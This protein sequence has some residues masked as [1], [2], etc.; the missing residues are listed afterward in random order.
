MLGRQTRTA[1]AQNADRPTSTR[2]SATHPEGWK[3]NGR[4]MQVESDSNERNRPNLGRKRNLATATTTTTTTTTT[5]RPT[6]EC[7]SAPRNDLVTRVLAVPA[8]PEARGNARPA[9]VARLHARRPRGAPSHIQV[10]FA[11]RARAI[12]RAMPPPLVSMLE[13]HPCSRQPPYVGLWG[14]APMDMI[15]HAVYV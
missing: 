4:N 10:V 9:L 3:G 5:H 15:R 2:S 1:A 6:S 11:R 14:D 7:T 12:L 8:V 13:L